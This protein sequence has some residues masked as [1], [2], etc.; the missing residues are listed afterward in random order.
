MLPDFF[1]GLGL[2]RRD[3]TGCGQIHHAADDDWRDLGI[4]AADRVGPR[5]GER[6]DVRRVDLFQRR[7]A[8]AHDIVAIHRPVAAGW[9]LCEQER[10]KRD[11]EEKRKPG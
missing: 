7:M 1:A 4:V 11:A 2:E 9:R 8:A 10:E 3:A 5:L 6:G